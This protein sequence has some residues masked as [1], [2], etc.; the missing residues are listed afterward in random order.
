MIQHSRDCNNKRLD[1]DILE[2]TENEIWGFISILILG[3]TKRNVMVEEIWSPTSLHY[4]EFVQLIMSR[5]RFKQ[6]S[7]YLTFDYV[8]GREPTDSKFRKMK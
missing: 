3:V 1:D 5:N 4:Q 8:E 7:R 2:F 6:L